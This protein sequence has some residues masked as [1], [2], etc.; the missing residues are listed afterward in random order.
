MTPLH[1]YKRAPVSI[2]L[3]QVLLLIAVELLGS[4]LLLGRW[5]LASSEGDQQPGSLCTDLLA[6]SKALHA[7]RQQPRKA[8]KHA[9]N[10]HAAAVH[11]NMQQQQRQMIDVG[12]D[13]SPS[14]SGV[15]SV[16]EQQGSGE[17][18]CSPR[19]SVRLQQRSRRLPAGE[20]R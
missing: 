9:A 14:V 8:G 7:A 3:L 18:P 4:K 13:V 2:P 1:T 10:L 16:L 17:V 12:G 5:A 19:R 6:P 11:A 20:Q 15:G